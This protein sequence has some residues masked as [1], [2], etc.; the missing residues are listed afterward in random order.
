MRYIFIFVAATFS[1]PALGQNGYIRLLDNDSV[2]T[3]F[4]RPYAGNLPGEMLEF[5]KT[6]YDKN[7]RRISKDDIFEYAIKRDTVRILHRYQ[8]FV[9]E[10]MY[11]ERLEVPIR[12]GKK[13]NIMSVQLGNPNPTLIPSAVGTMGVGVSVPIIILYPGHPYLYL[14]EDTNGGLPR[15]IPPKGEPIIDALKEFFPVR[16]LERYAEEFGPIKYQHIP[17]IVNLFNSK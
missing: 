3:G 1:L 11:F 2:L 8:P 5:W 10:S 17:K 13:I 12:H 6:K 7:P 9:D 16:Y 15:A 14:L 4:V